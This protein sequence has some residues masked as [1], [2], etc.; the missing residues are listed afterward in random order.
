MKYFSLNHYCNSF[1]YLAVF[2]NIKPTTITLVAVIDE[3]QYSKDY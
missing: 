2:I 3:T 1:K